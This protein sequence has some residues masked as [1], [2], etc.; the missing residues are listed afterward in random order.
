MARTSL[1]SL[2][3]VL[4]SALNEAARRA[5]AQARAVAAAPIGRAWWLLGRAFRRALL[6][7]LVLV[8]ALLAIY[9]LLPPPSMFGSD[10]SGVYRLTLALLCL[11]GMYQ[12]YESL[13]WL[14]RSWRR[15]VADP[16]AEDDARVAGLLKGAMRTDGVVSIQCIAVTSLVLSSAPFAIGALGVALVTV[17]LTLVMYAPIAAIVLL[18]DL[19][20]RVHDAGGRVALPAR[21]LPVLAPPLLRGLSLLAVVASLVFGAVAAIGAAHALIF[22]S[23]PEGLIK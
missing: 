21:V 11:C 16:A 18:A 12:S 6:V 9:A 10:D 7:K 15:P 22:P 23:S 20:L 8:P 4:A 5:P 2:L 19:G 3:G 1:F 14:V 13:E 17:A